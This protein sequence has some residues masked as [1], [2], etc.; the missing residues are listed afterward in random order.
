MRV[1]KKRVIT[2]G[3]DPEIFAFQ[4]DKLLPAYEFLP[5]GDEKE[6]NTQIYADGF[7]AEWKYDHYYKQCLDVLVSATH[8][9]LQ[10]LQDS[11]ADYPTAKLSLANVVRIPDATL[12]SADSAQVALGCEPSYNI[13]GLR[14]LA[15]E[16][17]RALKYRFCGGHMHFGEWTKDKPQVKTIV[18]TLDN[19]LG[20]WSVGA[21]QHFDDPIRRRYYGKPGEYRLPVYEEGLGVEYRV[22]SNFWL[23]SPRLMQLT[24]DIGR[25]C[26]RLAHSKHLP[27][28]S[29]NQQETIE[30][31][32]NCDV[33][34][35]RRIMGRNLP[36]FIWLLGQVYRK[37]ESIDLALT[38]FREGWEKKEDFLAD[39][40][41]DKYFSDAPSPSWG[42]FEQ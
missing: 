27:L 26:V 6:R 24:F 38:I 19:I 14:G 15:V 12:Q 37:Q 41:L 23:A 42:R 5:F 9:R 34:Q 22:L 33:R 3:S 1:S 36:M 31:I 17:P 25:L 21:A 11:L 8:G 20:V 32:T 29:G 35:A 4:G 13:Y 10:D 39:W 2:L 18:P 7:Q 16:N 40:H 30:T 28:W